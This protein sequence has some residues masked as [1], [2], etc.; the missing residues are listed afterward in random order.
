MINSVIITADVVVALVI[1]VSIVITVVV[2][3]LVAIIAA[4][5]VSLGVLG[6]E[7]VID[8]IAVVFVVHGNSTRWGGLV[9]A[10][11]WRD[12]GWS[13]CSYIRGRYYA[14]W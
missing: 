9:K 8:L 10:R 2:V 3:A 11:R 1:V 6:L 5:I 13:R 14:D 7:I 12:D 4:I